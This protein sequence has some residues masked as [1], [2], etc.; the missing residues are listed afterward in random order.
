MSVRVPLNLHCARCLYTAGEYTSTSPR[1]SPTLGSMPPSAHQLPGRFIA[2]HLL[3]ISRENY[4][5]TQ[6]PGLTWKAFSPIKI[7]PIKTYRHTWIPIGWFFQPSAKPEI[8]HLECQRCTAR[9]SQFAYLWHTSIDPFQRSPF[10]C[11]SL[12]S[13]IKDIFNRTKGRIKMLRHLNNMHYQYNLSWW[14][15]KYQQL[16]PNCHK[17][18]IN[19]DISK[20]AFNFTVTVNFSV[21]KIGSLRFPLSSSLPQ[22]TITRYREE[23]LNSRS[24]QLSKHTNM[25]LTTDVIFKLQLWDA[26]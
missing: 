2:L 20:V 13:L 23:F 25:Y 15:P 5:S 17:H 11:L 1:D 8:F 22:K 26:Y 24:C 3:K 16:E 7:M 6:R 9:E 12:N 14:T 4:Y 18:A 21:S 19:F 10:I